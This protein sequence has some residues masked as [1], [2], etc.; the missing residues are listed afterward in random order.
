MAVTKPDK[1][2]P[3]VTELMKAS[4]VIQKKSETSSATGRQICFALLATLWA[5]MYDKQVIRVNWV[6]ALA[7]F[8]LLC[9]LMVD[10]CQYYFS[11]VRMTHLFYRLQAELNE[12]NAVEKLAVYKLE[13]WKLARAVNNLFQ[14]KFALLALAFLIVLVLLFGLLT[15]FISPGIAH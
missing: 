6:T 11:S 1:E 3:H 12:Q 8:L 7:V 4:E 9:Y 15:G 10:V 5:M 14:I 13:Q 2:L